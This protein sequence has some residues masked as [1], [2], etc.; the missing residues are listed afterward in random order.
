M[1]AIPWSLLC[2]NDAKQQIEPTTGHLK[3]SCLTPFS[4]LFTNHFILM[5]I[6]QYNKR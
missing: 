3:V 1:A 6:F 4:C 2:S 5:W